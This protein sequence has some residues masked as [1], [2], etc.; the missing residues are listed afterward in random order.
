MIG[1][2]L[3]LGAGLCLLPGPLL[4]AALEFDEAQLRRRGLDPAMARYFSEAPRFTAGERRVA[5]YLNGRPLGRVLA[6]FGAQGELCFDAALLRAARL[7]APAGAGEGGC[8][9]FLASYPNTVV[10]LQPSDET[11]RL[12]VSQQALATAP[13]TEGGFIQGGS[14]GLLN[15][16]LY[17]ARQQAPWGDSQQVFGNTEL[18]VNAGN[19]MVRSRQTFAHANGRMRSQ[20]LS[21][22]AQTSLA[23]RQAILQLGQINAHNRVLAGVPLTGVQ[24]LPETA[25]SRG[26]R[27]LAP[28]EGI[29]Q[30]PARVE[31]HQ[32]QALVYSTLVPEGPFRLDAVRPLNRQQDLQVAVHEGSGEVRRFIVPI[33]SFSAAAPAPAGLALALGQARGYGGY[34][35][36]TPWV[37]S[38]SQGFALSHQRSLALAAIASADGYSGLGLALD[39]QWATHTGGAFSV[40]TAQWGGVAGLSATAALRHRFGERLSLSSSFTQRS[41]G[42]TDLAQTLAQGRYLGS[43]Q[44]TQSVALGGSHPGLGGYSLGYVQAFGGAASRAVN[45]G[46]NRNVGALSLSA[47]LQRDISPAPREHAGRRYR[48]RGGT[49]FYLSATVPLGGGTRL[50]A[51]ARDSGQGLQLGSS[52]SGRGSDRLGYQ[53][54]AAQGQ[55]QPGTDLGAQLNWQGSAARVGAGINDNGAGVRSY[56]GQLSGAAAWH[57]EGVTLGPAALGDTFAIATVGDVPGARLDTPAGSVWTDRQGRALIAHLPAY[58]DSEVRLATPSLPRNVDVNSAA[59]SVRAGRGA[60]AYVDFAVQRARR[61]LLTVRKPDGTAPA[62]GSAVLGADGQWVTAVGAAG[63]VYLLDA[64]AHRV[65]RVQLEGQRHCRLHFNLPALAGEQHY[66]TA[67]AQC[68]EEEPA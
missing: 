29:A 28:I 46:W 41:P 47:R 31:V 52:L 42:F 20:W 43:A 37:G 54:Q 57:A 18:G 17:G 21:T 3:L 22:Y 55:R 30:G 15:Y 10:E 38:I 61:L 12:V 25:L 53:V 7:K 59:Q 1:R 24:W 33:A 45:L 27:R 2:R 6:R 44:R 9:D 67:E 39:Q 65:L 36:A 34:R 50:G 64:N 60:V 5:L 49:E 13:G 48:E 11:V 68:L 40:A 26:A 66:Q 14:A 63:K 19:W 32:G 62:K 51:F 8:Q 56:T 16:D 58:R 4:A 23:E 35:T